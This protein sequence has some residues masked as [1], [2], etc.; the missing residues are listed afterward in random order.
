MKYE[1]TGVMRRM[2]EEEYVVTLDADT[3]EEAA[4][5]VYSVLSDFPDS[6]LSGVRVLCTSRINLS[7]PEVVSIPLERDIANDVEEDDDDYA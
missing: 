2:V 1:I 3:E 7:D 6:G 5:V 4:D